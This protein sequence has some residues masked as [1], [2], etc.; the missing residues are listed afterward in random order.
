[1]CANLAKASPHKRPSK[2]RLLKEYLLTEMAEHR[3]SA[4]GQ[5]PSESSLMR[6]FSMSRS[7]VRLVMVELA[8]KGFIERQQG[9]GTFRIAA[10]QHR[11]N[12]KSMLV[13]AWFNWL[14]GPLYGP[15]SRGIR[16]ELAFWDYHA[17]FEV[18]GME[19]G[20]ERRGIE[21]LMRKNLD[22]FIIGPSTNPDDDHGP[23]IELIK[24]RVP[25]VLVDRC[26]PGYPTDLVCTDNMLGAEQVTERLIQLGHRRIGF[27][28][29]ERLE[30][31]EDRLRGYQRTMRCHHLPLE[32]SWVQVNTQVSVDVGREATRALLALPDEQRP[33][34]IFAANDDIAEVVAREI[35]EHHLRIPE[36]VSLAGFDDIRIDS[37]QPAWL[38]TYAQPKY[39][40][41]QQAALLLIKRIK[42]PDRQLVNVVLGGQLIE[43]TST[44][45]LRASG[46][47]T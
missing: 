44:A 24:S 19:Y 9:R 2:A 36:D 8:S 20:A 10:G 38:T 21:S 27:I 3:I 33:T 47:M 22:G 25:L 31:V 46:V 6:Q 15:V 1:M 43:R 41:G 7:T 45:P 16:E 26:L 32:N 39:R 42:D 4:G 35:R 11:Q 23:L 30:T 18:E 37:K 28:G 14:N 17:V 5:L 40:I 29:I 13:G 12:P 34:A